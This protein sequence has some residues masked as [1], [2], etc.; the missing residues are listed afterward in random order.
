MVGNLFTN[1]D[2]DSIDYDIKCQKIQFLLNKPEVLE[3]L[4]GS[5][6]LRMT[7]IVLPVRSIKKT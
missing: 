4:S 6:S 7:N 5:R 1:D 2:L 3:H